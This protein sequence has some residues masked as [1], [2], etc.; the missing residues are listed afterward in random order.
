MKR[1]EKAAYNY[2]ISQGFTKI[3]YEPNGNIPPDFLLNDSIAVEIRR[4]NKHYRI[5]KTDKPLEEL[6]FKLIPRIRNLLKTYKTPGLDISAFLIITYGRPLKVDSTLFLD[7][8]KVLDDHL[9]FIAEQRQYDIRENLRIIISPSNKKF[10]SNYV[11][12]IIRDNNSAGFV[13]GDIYKNLNLI[14]DEKSF[15][16]APYLE[17][18]NEWWLVLIDQ[19]SYGLNEMDIKELR[20]LPIKYNSFKRIIILPPIESE[21]GIIL[22]NLKNTKQ[23]DHKHG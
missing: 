1:E 10:S 11:L 21:K 9:K 8:R 7:I 5:K 3:Q 16:I 12:G 18:Y 6:K 2:L 14:V 22:T 20:S 23:H 17:K 19:I 15:K 13:V 4:L